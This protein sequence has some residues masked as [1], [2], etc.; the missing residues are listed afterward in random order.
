MPL[1]RLRALRR[2]SGVGVLLFLHVWQEFKVSQICLWGRERERALVLPAPV[3]VCVFPLCQYTFTWPV[4]ETAVLHMMKAKSLVDVRCQWCEHAQMC[5]PCYLLHQLKYG[6]VSPQNKAFNL[7]RQKS[8]C[9][10]TLFTTWWAEKEGLNEVGVQQ[11]KIFP[12][13]CPIELGYFK[14]V[15]RWLEPLV[16]SDDNKKFLEEEELKR[17]KITEIQLVLKFFCVVKPFCSNSDS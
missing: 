3:C 10:Y 16:Q 2:N 17:K 8:K 11:M 15:P 12:F 5:L 7:G 9:P 4:A 13:D 14:A 6:H 1:T